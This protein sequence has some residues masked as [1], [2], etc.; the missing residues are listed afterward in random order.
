MGDANATN[1]DGSVIVGSSMGSQAWRWTQTTGAQGIGVLPGFNFRGYAFDLTEDGGTIVGTCGF[2]WDRDAFIWTAET[3]MLK[4]DTWLSDQGLDL[5]G[6]DLHTATGI[7]ED[8]SVIAGWGFGPGGIQGWLVELDVDRPADIDGDGVVGIT[9]L[10]I[11][12]AGWGPCNILCPADI[13]DD[14]LVNVLDLLM[15]IEDWG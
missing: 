5:A 12:I 14:G 1:S 3:G 2:G 8:A 11:V 15:V 6:W 4:L 9:D 7:S 13:N 10:L